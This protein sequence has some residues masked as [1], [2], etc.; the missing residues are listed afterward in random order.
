MPNTLIR[1]CIQIAPEISTMAKWPANARK[2]PRQKISS[3]CWPQMI[4]GS[5]NQELSTGQ[6]RGTN[7]TVSTAKRQEMRKAQHVEIGLVDRVHQVLDTRA[8]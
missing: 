2:T 3:E 1:T 5:N 8:A 4:A 6:V 7:R